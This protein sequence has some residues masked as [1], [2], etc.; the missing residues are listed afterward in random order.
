[1]AVIV[2]VAACFKVKYSKKQGNGR[3]KQ[4]NAQGA[5]GDER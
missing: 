5:E 3:T 1:M 4:A 2:L